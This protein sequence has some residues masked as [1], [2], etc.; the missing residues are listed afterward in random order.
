MKSRARRSAFT[1]IELLVV[2]AIIA[3]LIGLLLPA[4]QKVRSAA[5]RLQCINHLKQMG[6]ALHNYH[7][8]NGSFPPAHA[9]N[10][11]YVN[12]YGAPA[13]PDTKY[14][15][16]WMARILPHLEQKPLHDQINWNASPW[17]Q[18]PI[19]ETPIKVFICPADMRG[20][21]I[22]KYDNTD[23]VALTDYLAVSGTDQLRFDG[24]IHVN[25]TCKMI[26]I[27]DG[28]SNTLLIGERPP[29]TDLVYGWWFA[30]AGPAP[31]FGTTDVCLGVNERKDL[32]D[33]SNR[34]IYREGALNDPTNE[35]MWHFWSLHTGG[36]NFLFA[37]GSCRFVT[38]SVGQNILNAAATREGSE[39]ISI[40]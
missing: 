15:F 28:T 26:A 34:D 8:N 35:H 19:N 32:T 6:L 10:S 18:H 39:P 36:S 17:W 27:Q 38:Y 25:S 33:P 20:E 1:L 2:I 37:D 40:P 29:S 3:I 9:T 21:L 11:S 5:A 22:A 14:Y 24:I 7:D 23:L 13:S 30:G 16:S 31:N 12:T 4:V